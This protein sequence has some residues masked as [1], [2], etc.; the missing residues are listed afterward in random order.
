MLRSEGYTR[1]TWV[2]THI[3]SMEV[4]CLV[5]NQRDREEPGTRPLEE[6]VT[7]SGTNTMAVNGEGVWVALH[8]RLTLGH[9]PPWPTAREEGARQT[10]PSVY[11]VWK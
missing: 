8:I 7:L 11:R 5:P 6:I 4:H 10:R 1:H 9:T 3:P 2:Q